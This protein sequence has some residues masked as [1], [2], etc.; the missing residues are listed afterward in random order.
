MSYAAGAA[1]LGAATQGGLTMADTFTVE[2]SAV[3]GAPPEAVYAV[4]ADFHEWE[5]WSPWREMDPSQ[6]E[7][8]SGAEQG[9]GAQYA[10]K[11][12]RKVGEGSME[13]TSATA[14]S[15]VVIDLRFLKPF[16]AENVTTFTLSPEGDGTRVVWSL[17][18]PNTF[19]TKVMGI[20]KS[21]DK[22][23]GPDFEKGL[24]ALDAHMSS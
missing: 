19:M 1:L 5:H 3:I 18:G 17:V 10:W 8:Y 20:F 12:N 16:K 4:I 6:Q 24:A 2:R 7:T 9:A 13:I 23:I 15:E 11:G 14:P 21:M 22:M